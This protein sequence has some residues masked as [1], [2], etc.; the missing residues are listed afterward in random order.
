MSRRI[1][2]LAWAETPMGEISLRRRVEPTTGRD[3]YEVRLGEEYLMS[4]M[5][6]ASEVALARLGLAA[7]EPA[8]PD[9]DDA[10]LQV[11]VGGLGLGFT[12]ATALEDE[13]VTAMTV[14][15][16]LPQVIDWHTGGLLPGG[17]EL[18]GDPR[19]TLLHGDF[20]ALAAGDGFDPAQ[21]GRRWDAVLL[22]VDHTP[23]HVL[24]PSHAA[25]YSPDGLRS[26]ARL[27]RPG[28]VFALWSDD[29]PE[30][31]LQEV[32][33]GVFARSRS[34]VVGFDNVLTGGR[35]ACTVYVSVVGDRA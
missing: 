20:F 29:P 2:E 10:G 13:R 7:V 22:D 6:T 24:H 15:E 4:S 1:Q 14:V 16:A 25:F 19:T 33:D 26:L 30:T 3:V 35:S 34:H 27:V 28:G 8:G 21:P 32:L 9:A 18:V 17:A 23:R 11:V 12:A 31:E 5:F